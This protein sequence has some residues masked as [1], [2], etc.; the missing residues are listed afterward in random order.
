MRSSGESLKSSSE[1]YSLRR[2]VTLRKTGDELWE[3]VKQS[4][5]SL[6]PWFSKRLRKLTDKGCSSTHL[7]VHCAL[8]GMMSMILER[9]KLDSRRLQLALPGVRLTRPELNRQLD[10]FEDSAKA[11]E[12]LWAALRSAYV[13]FLQNFT[14]YTNVL[15]HAPILLRKLCECARAVTGRDSTAR[16]HFR[17]NR[18]SQLI[19]LACHVKERVGKY[20]WELLADLVDPW[21]QGE[22][23]TADIL[24]LRFKRRT[25]QVSED[26]LDLAQ[27]SV[28]PEFS[29]PTP[30]ADN[31]VRFRR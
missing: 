3:L 16:N 29:E 8:Y 20:H 10:L 2:W 27:N 18:D 22:T 13:D 9:H 21:I 12:Q 14:P 7:I 5:H 17:A 28:L 4:E 1:S 31:S 11:A 24:R 26:L 30:M 25:A 19:L 15:E 23:A 6:P